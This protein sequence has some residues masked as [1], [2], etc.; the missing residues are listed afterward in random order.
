MRL[1]IAGG[2][3]GGAPFIR[4]YELPE[5]ESPL[6]ADQHKHEANV[7]E[8]GKEP[9]LGG[10]VFRAIA[11]TQ[12]NG[13]VGDFLLAAAPA[14]G[15]SMTLISIPVHSGTLGDAVPI[16]L[17][18]ANANSQIAATTVGNT[19]Y[20]TIATNSL[21]D[22]AQSSRLAFFNPLDRRIVMQV[23]TELHRI[24][25][26]AYSPK[27][28][29]LFVANFPSTDDGG[30]GIYRIDRVNR[31]GVNACIASKLADVPSPTA[32]AFGPDGALYVTASGDPKS[33]NAGVLLKLT[34][35][36]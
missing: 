3:D 7:P 11:R 1:V 9:K 10:H 24:V 14:D 23:P 34:G 20:V 31:P 22:S 4:I 25:A 2:E 33:K 16:R 12:Y 18:N 29:N 27:S 17:E 8:S 36:L 15:G 32:L 19:G 35:V 28:G 21:G 6:T 13:R 26:L 5:P 30:A